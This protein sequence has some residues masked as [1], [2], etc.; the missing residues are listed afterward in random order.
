MESFPSPRRGFG[1]MASD[2]FDTNC[3]DNVLPKPAPPNEGD[4][5]E[6][7]ASW[8]QVDRHVVTERRTCH[9]RPTMPVICLRAASM[10]IAVALTGAGCVITEPPGPPMALTTFH[11]EFTLTADAPVAIRTVAYAATP[12]TL[13]M[14]GAEGYIEVVGRG[15]GGPGSQTHDDVWVSILDVESGGSTDYIYGNAHASVDGW[16]H[17]VGCA[18]APAIGASPLVPDRTSACHSSWMVVARWLD[19]IRGA[20][21]PLDVNGRLR[22]FAAAYPSPGQTFALSTFAVERASAPTFSGQPATTSAQLTGSA[23]ITPSSTPTTRHLTLRV[24]AALLAASTRFPRLGRIFIGTKVTGWSGPPDEAR[25]TMTIRD[26]TAAPYG[27][28]ASEF[29]WLTLCMP[30]ADCVLPIDLTVAYW[31]STGSGKSPS[32]DGFMALDWTM[33]ARLEDFSSTGSMPA[34][35]QLTE[36]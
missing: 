1:P 19:P 32:P 35:L 14:S 5:A 21:V 30:G 33:Q 16:G 28:I 13:A 20:D 23:R 17:S 6:T 25:V 9:L 8:L 36:P 10:L 3:L 7:P 31:E 27:S 22:A 26:R 34:Q 11:D 4:L 12:G 24:P 18:G 2:C 15:G 29:D